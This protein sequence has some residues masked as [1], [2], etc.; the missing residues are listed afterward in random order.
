MIPDTEPESPLVAAPS[1]EGVQETVVETPSPAEGAAAPVTTYR[2]VASWPL[3]DSEETDQTIDPTPLSTGRDMVPPEPPVAPLPL[4]E[5]VA[6]EESTDEVVKPVRKPRATTRKAKPKEL[7]A[8]IAAGDKQPL[9][10]YV[11]KVQSNR[12]KS[13]KDALIRRI[14]RDGLEDH[15]GEIHIP[16][17]KVVETKDGK[18]RVREQKLFPGYMMIHMCLN[19]ETWYLVRDTGG[20]GDFTG[21]AGRP[22]AMPE[23]EIKKML[24]PGTVVEGEEVRPSERPVMRFSVG[25]GDLVKVKTG[26]FQGFEGTVEKL[27]ETTGKVKVVCQVFGRPTEVELDHHQVEKA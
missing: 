13:I 25:E 16:V 22:S 21:S 26:A 5:P 24:G 11:L 10:W 17:E 20:V 1:S 19:D 18:R 23:S 2:Q 12:E 15:F 7:P 3:E 27:D 4:D 8:Q 6:P 9:Q 14:K